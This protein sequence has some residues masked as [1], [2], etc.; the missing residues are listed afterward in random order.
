M[1]LIAVVGCKQ[2]STS[3]PAAPAS[4]AEVD[5]LW[6]L[7]PDG[8][9]LGMV[10][11]PRGM[12]LVEHGYTGVM[13][14]LEG[15][16]ELEPQ[17]ADVRAELT[18]GIGAA[19]FSWQALGLSTQ[20]GAAMFMLPGKKG[21]LLVTVSD[22]AKF[23]KLIHQGKKA[24]DL[25]CKDAHGMYACSDE[26][27]A[28]DRI[29]KGSIAAS[30]AGARGDFEV[31]GKDL[32]FDRGQTMSF[33]VVAQLAPGAVTLRGG[34]SGLPKPALAM[35]GAA[36]TP[37]TEGDNTTGF[38]LAHVAGVLK[39]MPP[40][41]GEI[42]DLVKTIED[43]ITLVTTS[44]TIDL[45]VPLS[46]PAP[47]TQAL[48]AHCTEGPMAALGAK[49]IDGACQF[50]VPNL[51]QLT[52][53]IWV[54]GKTLHIGQKGAPSPVAVAPTELGKALA[55]GTWQFALY[56]RGSLLANY[57]GTQMPAVPPDGIGIVHLA[58]RAMV[59]VNELGAA[60]KIDGE[61]LR[62]V[63]GV[64]T[65][66]SNPDAVVAKLA[67]LDVDQ[68]IAGKGGDLAKP[69]IASAP[70]SPLAN[71][72]KAGY[73]GLMVPSAGVGMLAAVAIPAFLQYQN[74]S[75]ASGVALALNQL[76]KHLEAY[77]RDNAT[78]PI[79]DAPL[80]P[81]K[82]CC[83]QP[84]N[85]CAVTPSMFAGVWQKLDFQLDEPTIY[86]FGYHSDGKTVEITAVGDA[87]CDGKEATYTLE[88]AAPNGKPTTAIV[89]PP[90]GVY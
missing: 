79:G 5:A 69:I 65:A 75:K 76:G 27:T 29:G 85:K 31:A 41:P 58:M 15:T 38:A 33:A 45:R 50:A 25:V 7:A 64:R 49:L 71:D 48:I 56:G 86:R 53:G 83:G 51:P 47:A 46:D 67:A 68:L 10:V 36:T 9:T 80:T 78:F 61:T 2:A 52:V 63:F 20:K 18:K 32:P 37:R 11:S 87:D 74:R 72:V 16:P 17:L 21:L 24:Q 54:D 84:G 3:S 42:G 13:T 90:A 30:L 55:Q 28:F 43:P 44:T 35:F 73:M 81:D 22:K 4:T 40:L 8:A 34:F 14:F 1:A 89:P 88:A 59:M 57:P 66:W 77:Y 19:D 62:F 23:D 39:L 82:P 12:T 6:K 26:P 70:D 60:I